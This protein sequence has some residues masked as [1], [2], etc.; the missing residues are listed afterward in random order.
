MKIVFLRFYPIQ[1]QNEL[2]CTQGK[3]LAHKALYRVK[4][5][6]KCIQT[7]FRHFDLYMRVQNEIQPF[8]YS[9]DNSLSD[10]KIGTPLERN[11]MPS[12]R[13]KRTRNLIYSYKITIAFYMKSLM[14]R[15]WK[16]FYGPMYFWPRKMIKEEFWAI[17]NSC[18]S[19]TCQV[20]SFLI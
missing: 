14:W 15:D 5:N 2:V 13:S 12:L 4:R 9:H 18:N 19:L 6:S 1:N 8:L 20:L 16:R 17:K 7:Y 11:Q 3:Q 10:E